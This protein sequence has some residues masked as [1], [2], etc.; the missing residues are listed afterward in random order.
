MGV[1]EKSVTEKEFWEVLQYLETDT[2]LN[3][4][5]VKKE[6]EREIRKYSE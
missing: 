5:W 3:N 2:L 6:I 1:D 4:P